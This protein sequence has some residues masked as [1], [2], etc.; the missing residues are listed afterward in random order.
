MTRALQLT[1]KISWD[2]SEL[3][4]FAFVSHAF[5]S[6]GIGIFD[7]EF[8]ATGSCNAL[9]CPVEQTCYK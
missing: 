6:P 1:V 2:R 8:F 9:S 7:V 5:P 3:I 4:T